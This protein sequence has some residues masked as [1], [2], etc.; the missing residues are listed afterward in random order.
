[1]SESHEQ[2]RRTVR[3]LEDELHRLDS[4]DESAREVLREALREIVAALR[5]DG[6]PDLERETMTDR[7]NQAAGVFEGQHPTISG[8]IRRVVDGLGQ[9]GI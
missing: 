3:E 2:L 5:A 9:M 1:M 7:L 6:A 8:I 4:V